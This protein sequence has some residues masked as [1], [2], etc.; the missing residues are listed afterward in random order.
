MDE[1]SDIKS[2]AV[3]R[4]RGRGVVNPHEVVNRMKAALIKINARVMADGND[5]HL[6]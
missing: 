4:V 6:K 3:M 1:P 2:G 5:W